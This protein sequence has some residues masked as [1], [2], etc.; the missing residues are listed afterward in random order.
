MNLFF[1]SFYK[2]YKHY[3]LISFNSYIR[4]IKKLRITIKKERKKLRFNKN[5]IK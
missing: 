1:Y 3:Y 2:K 5:I 4:P